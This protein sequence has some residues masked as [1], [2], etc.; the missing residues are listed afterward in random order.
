MTNQQ[1]QRIKRNMGFVYLVG[2]AVWVAVGLKHIMPPVI[3]W[4]AIAFCLTRVWLAFRPVG[5]DR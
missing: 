3:V 4:V 2:V 5:T 1:M